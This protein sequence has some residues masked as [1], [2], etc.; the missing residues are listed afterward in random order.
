MREGKKEVV[1]DE[2]KKMGEIVSMY[3]FGLLLNW[4]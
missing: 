2:I 3:D 4:V 1:K